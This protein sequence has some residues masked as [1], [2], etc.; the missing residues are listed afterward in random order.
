[1][2]GKI[3][4]RVGVVEAFQAASEEF[5]TKS[6]LYSVRIFPATRGACYPQA[7]TKNP[8]Q[9]ICVH[10]TRIGDRCM[11]PFGATRAPK[12]PSITD[13]EKDMAEVI[14]EVTSEVEE[15]TGEDFEA[16]FADTPLIITDSEVR[17]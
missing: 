6:H 9:M 10:W 16:L 1:M 13:R 8:A 15:L 5:Q 14:V 3:P 12:V 11:F 4:Q 17:N 7:L 2:G